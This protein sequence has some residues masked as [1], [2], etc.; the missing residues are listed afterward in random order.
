MATFTLANPAVFPDGTSVGAYPVSNW[1][2]PGVP[3]GAPLGSATNTQTMTAGTLSFTG[4]TTGVEYYAVGQVGG[5]Y[6]Y[7]RFVAGEDSSGGG[8]GVSLDAS[9]IFSAKQTFSADGPDTLSLTGATAGLH[10]APSDA[11]LMDFGDGEVGFSIDGVAKSFAFS[12]AFGQISLGDDTYL[13]RGG[14]GQLAI[15]GDASA[16]LDLYG[17]LWILG[18]AGNGFIM[19]QEQSPIPAAPNPDAGAI[20]FQDNGA[21]KTQLAVRFNTGAVQVIATEP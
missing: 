17:S 8:G 6:R 12:L 15:S 11:Y 19:G 16:E 9:N 14:P 5:V 10:F 4:L 18:E 13:L 7:V 21:G 3:S 1:P 2:T 20:F